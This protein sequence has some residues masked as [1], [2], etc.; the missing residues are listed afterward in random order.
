[1]Q[2]ALCF[3]G[4]SGSGK[5]TISSL[6]AG[7]WGWPIIST[8]DLIRAESKMDTPLG[9]KCRDLERD[10]VRLSAEDV[11]ELD[12]QAIHAL[13]DKEGI[14]FEGS[15]RSVQEAR[16][17]H[18]HMNAVFVHLDVPEEVCRERLMKRRRN[19]D[20]AVQITKRLAWFPDMYKEV[21]SEFRLYRLDGTLAPERVAYV[22]E[23]VFREWPTRLQLELRILDPSGA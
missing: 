15:P 4:R 21:S 1:M 13:A 23:T 3:F 16:F 22:I 8:G 10:G 5:G 11:I 17:L 14:I 7:K 18:R 9:Q 2:K 19:D 20:T 6:I 12:R